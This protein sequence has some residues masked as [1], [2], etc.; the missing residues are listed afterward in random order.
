VF[1]IGS[2]RVNIQLQQVPR[3]FHLHHI[4]SMTLSNPRDLLQ[5]RLNATP[6]VVLRGV[7]ECGLVSDRVHMRLRDVSV[8]GISG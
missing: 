4:S 5:A 1:K 2:W 8:D 7:V 3:F 6:L